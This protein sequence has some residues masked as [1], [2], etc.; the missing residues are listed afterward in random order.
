MKKIFVIFALFTMFF[1]VSC[2]SGLKFN[3]PYDK[4]SADLAG[5]DTDKTDTVSEYSDDDGDKTDT[6]SEYGDDDGDKTDTMSE[7]GDDDGDKTDT[8]SEYGDDD[9]NK[10]DTT[11]EYGDDDGDPDDPRTDNDGGSSGM[12]D[13]SGND[14]DSQTDDDTAAGE[15]VPGQKQVCEYHGP[16]ETEG[17][18]PC[19]AAIKTCGENGKWGGCEGEILPA[20]ETGGLCSDGIDNDCNGA[21]DDG[22]DTDGDGYGSCADCCETADGCNGFDP[23]TINPAAVEIYGDSLDNNCNGEIDEPTSCDGG[24]GGLL[25]DDYPGN[26]VKLAHAMGI[27]GNQLVEAALSLA[28]DPVAE[29]IADNGEDC[30]TGLST[31][32][33][34]SSKKINRTSMPMPYYDDKYK[35]FA[36]EP[37]FG[38]N[39]TPVEGT[40]IA[41][42][43]T[44]PWNNPTKDDSKAAL[45]AGDMKTAST[46]PEDWINMMPDCT[47]PKAPSCGGTAVED[48][49]SNQ[50]EEK[51]IPSVQD[52]IM[53]TVRA[54]V[55]MNAHA[56]EF[57]LF[58]LSV[59]YP[60]SVCSQKNYNDFFIALLDSTYNETNPDAGFKNPADKNIA[61][62]GNGNPVGINLAPVGLF[63]VCGTNGSYSENCTQGTTLLEGTGFDTHNS[64]GTGWLTTRGNVVPGETITL[65]LALWEQGNV[66]YGPDHSWDSTVLLDGFKWLSAPVQAGI[67]QQ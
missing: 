31:T 20:D 30:S 29:K 5:D 8:V 61:K 34:C 1:S 50:C 43:S 40:K 4:N 13:D 45:T 39:I 66:T 60:N 22:I 19:R 49:L 54:K 42:L 10:T 14:P 62:D 6:V 38:N 23:A 51:D 52:P 53:L 2:D 28:G 41:I 3:N 33:P 12:T 18:G 65:R 25:L 57:R 26:A 48:N 58:F 9:G 46:I 56:F 21:V 11:S 32:N 37:K 59:E 64:G 63:Q 67:S 36:A 16:A 55:P 7:Y 44:G 17:I 35:T 27:C 47:V 24:D 15:C